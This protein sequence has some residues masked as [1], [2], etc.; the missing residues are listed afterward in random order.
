MIDFRYYIQSIK[1]QHDASTIV[2]LSLFLRYPDL[3]QIVVFVKACNF[4]DPASLRL[5]SSS[6]P[7]WGSASTTY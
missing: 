4:V 3:W 2:I 5:E 1:Y 6:T 7:P